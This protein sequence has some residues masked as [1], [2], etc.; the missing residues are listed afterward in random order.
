M[1]REL[2]RTDRGMTE[3][4]ARALLERGEYGVLATVA[5][6]GAPYVVPL[7]YCVIADAI[8]FH[9]AL[10]G[11]KLENIAGEC[12]VSFCVVGETELLPAKFSTRYESVI[13]AGRATEVFEAEKTQGLAGLVAK[14]SADFTVA[15]ARYIATDS[16]KTRVFRIDIDTICGKARR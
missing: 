16:P 15:G 6:D 4:E 1:A 9:C 12:R 7:S 8:Y 3:T 5:A 14:Y 11:H 2:R 13:V 10:E